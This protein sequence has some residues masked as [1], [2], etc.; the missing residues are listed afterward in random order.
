[1]FQI[2]RFVSVDGR[3]EQVR[4]LGP[5]YQTEEVTINK[6]LDLQAI[7]NSLQSRTKLE[8]HSFEEN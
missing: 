4:P 1:M 6:M 5:P 8:I 3:M 2:Y 7:L